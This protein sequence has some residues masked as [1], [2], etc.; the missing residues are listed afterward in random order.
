M[1]SVALLADVR[2]FIN[3]YNAAGSQIS[4]PTSGAASLASGSWV[5]RTLTATAPDGAVTARYGTLIL[6]SPAAGAVLYSDDITFTSTG[7]V[8][9]TATLTRA[10]N[11]ISKAQVD[12]EEVHLWEPFILGMA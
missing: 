3:W 2:V 10:V 5:Q 7:Y 6:S 11:S 4:T 8:Y 1:R 12:G 9:Q